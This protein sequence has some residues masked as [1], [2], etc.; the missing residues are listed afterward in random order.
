MQPNQAQY[1]VLAQLR[2]AAFL[3]NT[4]KSSPLKASI[5]VRQQN[6]KNPDHLS[7]SILQTH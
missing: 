3:Q 7:L 4:K 6:T 2:F 5:S 1:L